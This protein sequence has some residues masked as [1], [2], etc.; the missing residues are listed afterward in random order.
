M[1]SQWGTPNLKRMAK[2]PITQRNLFWNHNFYNPNA[3]SSPSFHSW[4][5][6][7]IGNMTGTVHRESL[8]HRCIVSSSY[9]RFKVDISTTKPIPAG[10]FQDRDNRGELWIQFKYER[11]ADFCYTCGDLNHVTEK[12]TFATPA[13]IT[14]TNGITACLWVVA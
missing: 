10:F 6:S 4:T 7:R 2:N 5:T 8:N 12:C 14:T 13:T 3:W 11:L 1:V 9:L